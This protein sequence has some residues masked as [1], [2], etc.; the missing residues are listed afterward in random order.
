M[1]KNKSRSDIGIIA[2]LVGL[3]TNITLSI[4]KLLVGKLS[5]SQAIFAD[6]I[7]SLSD[8]LSSLITVI[9]FQV[10]RKPADSNHPY[11]HERSEYIAGFTVSLIMIYLGIDVMIGAA[12]N[13]LNPKDLVISKTAIF[14]M[15]VSIYAKL[16]LS[17]YYHIQSKKI[18]STSL[19]ASKQD[20]LNDVLMSSVILISLL[21][22]QR[23]DFNLDAFMGLFL[24]L[25][26]CYTSLK[27]IKTF[28]NELLG[29]RPEE[30]KLNAIKETLNNDVDIF[31]YH[32]LLVHNYGNGTSYGSVHIEMDQNITL[33][34]AHDI[35]DRLEK[36]M[37]D[38]S[39]INIVAHIDPLDITNYELHTIYQII[40]KFLRENYP[41]ASFHDMRLVEDALYFD[42]VLNGYQDSSTI[43]QQLCETLVHNGIVYP[44]Y[45][46][47][48]VQQLI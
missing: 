4:L 23:L 19:V 2:G 42:L 33:I 11:G 6:G 35:T 8:A 9:G 47:Y 48:D 3:L 27:M 22:N 43:Q 29:Q 31:G 18:N 34:K 44:V 46:S 30:S 21:L 15:L 45:I 40:K 38:V 28:I 14:I 26:I 41:N 10:A 32:D 17:I 39:G 13:L 36:A 12:L 25:F 37:F 24:G 1:P 16:I 5:N 20:S 7:N